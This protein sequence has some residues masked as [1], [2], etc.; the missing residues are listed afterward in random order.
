MRT[1]AYMILKCT[2][3]VFYVTNRLTMRKISTQLEAL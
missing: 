2:K 3:H 1:V